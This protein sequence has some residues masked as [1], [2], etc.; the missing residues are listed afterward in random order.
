MTNEEKTNEEMTSRLEALEEELTAYNQLASE[1]ADRLRQQRL[2]YEA[3]YAA[4][5]QALE[6]MAGEGM[7]IPIDKAALTS[8]LD[9]FKTLAEDCNRGIVDP[10]TLRTLILGQRYES[11]IEE[12]RSEGEIRGRNARIEEYLRRADR[13]VGDGTP[14][15]GGRNIAAPGLSPDCLGALSRYGSSSSD[16]WERGKL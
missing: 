4:T 2:D 11:D 10:A 15:I 8:A 12:A 7:A 6:D 9:R 1:E 3:N 16:I 14:S 5:L 13:S